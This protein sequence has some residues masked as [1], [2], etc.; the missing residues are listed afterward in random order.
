[1]TRMK[2]SKKIAFGVS[3]L[4]SFLVGMGLAAW[5]AEPPASSRSRPISKPL[6][7]L[8]GKIV[9]IDRVSRSV[10]VDI[11]GTVLRINVTPEVRILKKGH[12]TRL[13]DLAAGQ[14]VSIGFYER[15]NG[16]LEVATVQIRPQSAPVQAA[17][18]AKAK[19]RSHKRR[20]HSRR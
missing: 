13:E 6:P 18:P 19:A 7:H 9:A 3:L 4:V 12:R 20:G 16:R 14:T 17:G 5:S 10:S 2:K 11:K 15:P 8:Q 1:M